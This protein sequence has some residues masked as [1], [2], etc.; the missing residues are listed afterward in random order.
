[1]AFEPIKGSA[2]LPLAIAFFPFFADRLPGWKQPVWPA[3]AEKRRYAILLALALA[4]V[5]IKIG[6]DAVSHEA[7][8]CGGMSL[9][10]A[11]LA[12]TNIR[13]FASCSSPPRSPPTRSLPWP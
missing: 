13:C 3:F 10:L 2:K 11:P 9:P 12:V 1:M 4:V 6:E 7:G 5:G 8:I